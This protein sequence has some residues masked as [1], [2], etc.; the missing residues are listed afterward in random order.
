MPDGFAEAPPDPVARDGIA[1]GARKSKSD[2]RSRRLRFAD[3]ERGKQGTG[4]L[5]AGVVNPAEIL[6]AQQTDTFRKTSDK[7][8]TSR[9]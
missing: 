2:P 8:T 1:Q 5:D 4:V 3:A 9:S 6:G 7:G